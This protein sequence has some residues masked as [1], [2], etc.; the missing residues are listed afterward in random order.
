MA[1]PTKRE[2]V[3]GYDVIKELAKVNKLFQ[4][5]DTDK[6]LPTFSN[7]FML[8]LILGTAENVNLKL[9]YPRVYKKLHTLLKDHNTRILAMRK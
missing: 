9:M 7:F 1:K 6:S 3:K 2:K 8:C 5:I 4:S